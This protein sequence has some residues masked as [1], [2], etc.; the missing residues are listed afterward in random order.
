MVITLIVSGTVLSFAISFWG[1]SATLQGDLSTYVSRSDAGDSLREAFNVSSGLLVQNSIP[2]PN[3]M[4]PDPADGSGQHWEVIHAIPG[5]IP[6]GSS[7]TMTPVAYYQAPATTRDKTII[8]NGTQPYANEFVLYLNGTTKQLL[9]RSLAN[10]AATDNSTITSCPADATTASCPA[11]K[12]ICDN[13]SSVDTRYFSRSGN[14]IDWTSI[15]ERDI[16]GN[17]VVPTVYIGPDFPAVEVV[18]FTLHLFQKSTIHGGQDT[19]NSTIIR[20]AIRNS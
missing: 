6:I 19:I 1:V 11:D 10:P 2:D 3:A 12:V 20:V 5:N 17:P 9:L 13:I 16:D 14:T 8:M 4:V 15:I 7:G 18:E